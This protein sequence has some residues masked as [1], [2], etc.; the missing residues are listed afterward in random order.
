MK[1][2]YFKTTEFQ[3]LVIDEESGKNIAVTYNPNDARLIA[4]A[5]QLL[6]ALQ[7]LLEECGPPEKPMWPSAEAMASAFKAINEATS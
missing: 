2:W 5:P 6:E 7:W 1:R 3:G 4:A